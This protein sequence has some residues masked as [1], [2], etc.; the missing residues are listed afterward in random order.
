MSN[1]YHY[2]FSCKCPSDGQTIDY[3]IVI[4]TPRTI[5]V[6]DIRNFASTH[7]KGFQEDLADSFHE[8]FGGFQEIY[9]EHQGVGIR[10]QRGV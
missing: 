10:T 4:S 7:E 9:A 1:S 6:E 3:Y 5:L 8:M 2:R